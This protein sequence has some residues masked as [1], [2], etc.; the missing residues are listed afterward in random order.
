MYCFCLSRLSGVCIFRILV[1]LNGR[2]SIGSSSANPRFRPR[3]SLTSLIG[4]NQRLRAGSHICLPAPT[5]V[6]RWWSRNLQSY[7]QLMG[8]DAVH[9]LKHEDQVYK[10]L[11]A[12][13]GKAIPVYVGLIN[14][15]KDEIKHYS[16]PG[17]FPAYLLLKT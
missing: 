16:S 1:H 3:G 15:S 7:K 12:I 14:F 13:Q 5:H 11:R 17:R 2:D 8:L 6:T 4:A 9:A 10:K